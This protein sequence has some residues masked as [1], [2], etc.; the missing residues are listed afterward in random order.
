MY[1]P[2]PNVAAVNP[3]SFDADELW[4]SP[5]HGTKE[6]H[7]HQ[8]AGQVEHTLEDVRAP[9]VAHP[10]PAKA[11]QPSE[12]A[13]CHPAVAT[14]PLARVDATSCDA[15]GDASDAQGT[16]EAR[17]IVGFVGVQLGRASARSPR[18]APWPDDGWN[19]IDKRNEL[20]GVVRVGG[21]EPHGQRDA[22]AVNDEVV[23]GAALAAV[24]DEVVLGAALAAV[25][26]VRSRLLAP[27][28]ARTLKES[29]LARV[30]STAAS[31]P[32]QFSSVSCN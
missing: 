4:T 2:P 23:L 22:A 25:D 14:E 30:Q 1:Q 8:G 28:L 10:E 32:S 17:G 3:A 16:A 27:L 15:R 6:A 11:E 18:L 7:A 24:N 26:R 12:R 21:R 9:L 29:A 5:V 20:G 19:R 13:L 31:S